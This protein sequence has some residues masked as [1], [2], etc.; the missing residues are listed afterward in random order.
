M[1]RRT[2]SRFDEIIKVFRKYDFDKFLGQTTRNKISPFRSD[3]DNKELLKEDFPERLRLMFQELGTTF[4]KF[5]QLLASRP[6]LVG[7]R[8]SEEL[9]QL[10]DDNPPVSFEEIK[11]MI[12]TQLGGN[13]EDLFEEFSE[14]P[15]ATAS[16]AQVHE[17][18]LP[19]GERV[20]VKVQKTN[21]E[22]IVE[23]D[24]SIMKFIANE[25][26]RFNTSLKHLNL[27]AV[28]HE[29]DKSIHKEMDFD[30]ELMNIRHLNDNFKYN[31]KIIVP[32]I[33]PDYSTEKVLTMEYVEGVKLSEVIAGDDPKY[34][35]IL[36]ADRI[37]R[38]Y[39]QQLFIDG[40]FHADPHPGNIFVA[41]DNAI[42]YIDFGMM[43]VLDEDFR[44]DLAELMIYFSDRNI[45]GLI[46]QLI[47][48]DILNE[49]T[50]INILKSDLND[51]FAKYYGVELS[52]FNGII[53]DL[54]FLMQKFDVRLPNEFVLMARGLSMV[55][56]T[57]LRLDPDID[58]V[59]LLKPFARK[60][61][62]QRYNP[63]KM[64]SN[65][66][67]SF[68][69]F[70]HVL[71]ALPSLISKTI[72]KVEEGEVTVNIE[73]KHISEIANQLSLAIIIAALLVGS[74][75]VMLIDVGP[76]FY[77]MPVL[78]FV[79]FTISLALGVFTVLRYFIDF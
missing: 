10:H 48:M 73:V 29:F 31:D 1:Q 38:S 44:Q 50:D 3:A 76:R 37:V 41:D 33:Y 60:L 40:F 74:S 79:G 30:N 4:I 2:L 49:K 53:E 66:K 71:R 72:Y 20:A 77:E 52:R 65:A 12:E 43:G 22:E 51:L 17:A 39:F 14:S 24:L 26:D 42:C 8:I 70:E 57:G 34:N 25:S 19:T 63:L 18:K 28:L 46:N 68:F 36:I 47:R 54:L 56:N 7:E 45:D 58:V 27:P 75:L 11:E 59:A 78:G 5:G 69:A 9:S 13:I 55:E 64:A 62:V 67:N 15:L 32:T 23:T 6:D 35:K 16:I 21:V 61:M